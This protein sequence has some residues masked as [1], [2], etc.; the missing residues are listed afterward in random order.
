MFSELGIHGSRL[1]GALVIRSRD[2]GLWVTRWLG[3]LVVMKF[4][5]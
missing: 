2:M 1:C 5:D 4:G 3:H